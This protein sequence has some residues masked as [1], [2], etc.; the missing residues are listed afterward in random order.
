MLYRATLE[1]LRCFDTLHR[2]VE[3]RKRTA[4]YAAD[5]ERARLR[6][7]SG[8]LQGWLE[9]LGMTVTA[10][11]LT[12]ANLPRIA[13]LLN[14]T[15]QMNLRTRR[16][17]EKELVDWAKRPENSV[18]SFTVADRFGSAGLTGIVGLRCHERTALIEDFVLSCRVIGRCVE[19]TILHVASVVCRRSGMAELQAVL[20][21]TEKNGPCRD[22]LERSGLRRGATTETFVWD[23]SSEYPLPTVI[24]LRE[25]THSADA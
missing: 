23:L 25:I 4:L 15:N 9:G 7:T 20:L 21:P 10:E 17:S 18:W 19:E 16:L 14:K 5:S 11:P 1:G 13:Q 6:D 22:F 12:H 2:S 3:D 24:A 8:S